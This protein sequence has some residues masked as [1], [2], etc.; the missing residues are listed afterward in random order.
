MKFQSSS[1]VECSR[2]IFHKDI[3]SQSTVHL[4]NTHTTA[5]ELET[6]T[7][8]AMSS[9]K[10]TE[11]TRCGVKFGFVKP[12]LHYCK[13][14]NQAVCHSCSANRVLLGEGVTFSRRVCDACLPSVCDGRVGAGTA[15]PTTTIL[16]QYHDD[17]S[18]SA[19]STTTATTPQ[20]QSVFQ[21]AAQ[22][23]QMVADSDAMPT[24][25]TLR[26]N[27]EDVAVDEYGFVEQTNEESTPA[28]REKAARFKREYAKKAS[29]KLKDWRAYLATHAGL[30]DSPQ[31][32]KL[33][34]GG[35]PA[36]LR[37]RVWSTM[38]GADALRKKAPDGYYALLIERAERPAYQETAAAL[39]I[40]KDLLRTFPDN[41]AFRCGD[42]N[43]SKDNSNGAKKVDASNKESEGIR[44]LR[45]I[46]LA[47]SLRNAIVGYC[48]S[49]NFVVGIFLFFMEEEV[50]S[51]TV[52]PCD[53]I[54]CCV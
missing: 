44:V 54:S 38:S 45:R 7:P 20:T 26:V 32:K 30:S 37:G 2:V 11:C 41:I 17:A 28:E 40:E 25:R 22:M 18:S 47:Y 51:A 50:R 35:V 53:A 49:L 34:R 13:S 42:N 15:N 52:E 10:P 3:A 31:L 29:Q 9:K 21:A 8:R 46:L 19:A 36:R 14:C 6:A 39:Q 5:L 12:R 48:Q 33:V 24:L 23:K 27:D 4:L 16:D 43:T 1:Q